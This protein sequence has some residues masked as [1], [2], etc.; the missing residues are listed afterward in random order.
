MLLIIECYSF[1]LPNYK[2]NKSHLFSDIKINHYDNDIPEEMNNYFDK[3]SINVSINNIK[4]EYN[5]YGEIPKNV[6]K[7]FKKQ[8]IKKDKLYKATII[9]DNYIEIQRF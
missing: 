2:E 7:Y 4:N 6:K 3:Q 8:A 1:I 5:D 9:L